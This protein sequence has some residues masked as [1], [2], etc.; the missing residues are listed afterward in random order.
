MR[1][2]GKKGG[3]GEDTRAGRKW[4]GRRGRRKQR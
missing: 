3:G 2:K 4:G 1:K